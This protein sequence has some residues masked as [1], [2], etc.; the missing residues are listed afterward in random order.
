VR[1]VRLAVFVA[2]AALLAAVA[3]VLASAVL[4]RPARYYRDAVVIDAPRSSI[5][6]LLT[7]FD[8][9]DEW[10]PYITDGSGTATPGA[11]VELSFRSSGE[12]DTETAEVLIVRPMRKLEWRTRV[13]VPGMLDREQIFRV[14][15]REDGRW[16]VVQEVRLEG[17]LAP[18]TDFDDDRRGLVQMLEALAERAPAYQSSA[19]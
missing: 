16:D 18:L 3:A 7:E 8:R 12:A 13:V 1:F 9:Y 19:P 11:D 15:P 10:N 4:D 5:W 2:V 6:A 14:L 17:V